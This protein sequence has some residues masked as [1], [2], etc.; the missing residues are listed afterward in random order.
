[1]RLP[2]L[3]SQI[4]SSTSRPKINER[5]VLMRSKLHCLDTFKNAQKSEH[6]RGNLKMNQRK[7]DKRLKFWRTHEFLDV[8]ARKTEHEP[9]KSGKCTKVRI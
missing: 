6:E 8:I 5:G 2:R 1:M 9:T 3:G 7:S 4:E